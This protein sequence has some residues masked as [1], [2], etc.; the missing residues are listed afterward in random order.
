MKEYTQI[1]FISEVKKFI[2]AEIYSKLCYFND[3]FLG[4]A[5]VSSE[6]MFALVLLVVVMRM[7]TATLWPRRLNMLLQIVRCKGISLFALKNVDT[8][9]Q[10]E[11]T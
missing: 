8:L 5:F 11:F 6:F 4:L 9:H 3:Y 10:F 2:L 7:M 1:S